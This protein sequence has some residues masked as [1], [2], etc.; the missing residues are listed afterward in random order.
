MNS[1]GEVE[2]ADI[3]KAESIGN[4]KIAIFGAVID[5]H[6]RCF[7]YHS[8]LDIVAIKFKCCERYYPCFSCHEE[9]AGHSAKLWEEEEWNTTAILCGVCRTEMTINSYM[10]CGNQCPSCKSPFNPGCEKHY[11]LYFHI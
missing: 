5:Q 1:N 8:S 10:S 11:H 6:T 3:E 7:H 4:V 2:K 9:T